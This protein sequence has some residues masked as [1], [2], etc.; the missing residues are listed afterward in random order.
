MSFLLRNSS[1]ERRRTGDQVPTA[2]FPWGRDGTWLRFTSART[3]AEHPQFIGIEVGDCDHR[4]VTRRP[5]PI[6]KPANRAH[7]PEREM[8]GAHHE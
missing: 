7:C 1:L 5:R 4:F 3:L 8:F 2:L 6:V